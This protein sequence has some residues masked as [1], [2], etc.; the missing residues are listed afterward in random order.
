MA[1]IAQSMIADCLD[2]LSR[3]KIDVLKDFS[4]RDNEVDA[5]TD[6]VRRELITIMVENPRSIAQSNRLMF[7]ALHLE[8]IAD[9]ACNIASRIFYM[10][11]GERIKFE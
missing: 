10:V 2:A 8:R 5:L 7:A 3:E 4:D 11:S 1:E 6:Q 9:H